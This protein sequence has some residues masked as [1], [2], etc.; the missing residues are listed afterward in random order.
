MAD[1]TSNLAVFQAQLDELLRDL[2]ALR[3]FYSGWETEANAIR[4]AERRF[5][6]EHPKA[7]GRMTGTE[8]D[9]RMTVNREDFE[10]IQSRLVPN[11]VR[12]ALDTL[13]RHSVEFSQLTNT[14]KAIESMSVANG[15]LDFCIPSSVYQ[16]F[17]HLRGLLKDLQNELSRELPKKDA[18]YSEDARKVYEKLGASVFESMANPAILKSHRRD[19]RRWLGKSNLKDEAIRSM[20]RRIREHHRLPSSSQVKKTGQR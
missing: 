3:K 4:E 15:T 6:E 9:R 14:A 17:D 8:L 5:W 20:L 1:S 19:I 13:Y 11:L 2:E 12:Q 16:V 18:P 7:W 10:L